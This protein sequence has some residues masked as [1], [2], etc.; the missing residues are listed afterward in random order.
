[1]R[2]LITTLMLVLLSI[3]VDAQEWSIKNF[4]VAANDISASQY[5][6]KDDK[7]TA[8]ALVK[9]LMVGSVKEVKGNVV[10]EVVNKG[11]EKWVYVQ[12][13]S[14]SLQL[15]VAEGKTLS[16]VFNSFGIQEV[17]SKTTY[18][19][20]IS[21]PMTMRLTKEVETITVNGITFKLIRVDGGTFTMGSN[22]LPSEPDR[23]L[24]GTYHDPE[25][26]V[27]LSTFY[28]CETEI[29][30]ELWRS[31]NTQSAKYANP[32]FPQNNVSWF[33]CCSFA[34]ELSQITGLNF[35]L[36]TEAEWEYAAKGGKK[37]KGYKY[38]GSN[39]LKEAG[40]WD[41]KDVDLHS[42]KYSA[43]ELG[44]YDMTGNVAEWCLDSFSLYDN[45]GKSQKDPI[46]ENDDHPERKCV[47]GGSYLS[48]ERNNKK[49]GLY[50]VSRK[51]KTDVEYEREL[52]FRLVVP[53]ESN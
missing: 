52:G 3:S 25:H 1:M 34:E 46:G 2:N 6:R 19:L 38:S 35:R 42:V 12:K 30:N 21:E 8:C 16:V 5:E 49:Y 48:S 9:I 33:E 51:Y 14:K 36:P 10:G 31:I 32:Q 50:T 26:Q 17:K 27:T 24:Y 44:I 15:T 29:T 13:G 41:E 39:N 43:N 37:S 23:S 28:I 53:V 7:G 4:S 22:K 18:L 20:E 45:S 11:S 47:R 40:W